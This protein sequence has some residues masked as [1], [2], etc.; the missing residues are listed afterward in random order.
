MIDVPALLGQSI[1]GIELKL[2]SP[3][4]IESLGAGSLDSLPY[5]GESRYYQFKNETIFVD[6]YKGLAVGITVGS[7]IFGEDYSFDDWEVALYRLGLAVTSRPDISGNDSKRW[8]NYQG[9]SIRIFAE[10]GKISI[11]QIWKVY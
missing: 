5:G 7:E 2:G 1:Q 11:V 6:Y 8:K 4:Q 10:N 3:S 9:Y